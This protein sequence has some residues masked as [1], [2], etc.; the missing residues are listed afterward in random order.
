MIISFGSNAG[1]GISLG[2]LGQN[3]INFYPYEDGIQNY[4]G[5]TDYYDR[6]MGGAGPLKGQPPSSGEDYTRITRYIDLYGNERLVFVMNDTVCV[7]VGNGYKELV[8]LNGDKIDGKYYPSM[9]AHQGKLVILNRG[10]Y[11]YIWDGISAV[12]TIGIHETPGTPDARA[13]IMPWSDTS[14]SLSSSVWTFKNLWWPGVVPDSGPAQNKDFDNVDEIYGIYRV[15]VQFF[16]RYGNKSRLSPASLEVTVDNFDNDSN[17]CFLVMDFVTPQ[18]SDSVYGVMIGRTLSLNPLGGTG[19]ETVF[20]NEATI[21]GTSQ[22]RHTCIMNDTQLAARPVMSNVYPPQTSSFGCSWKGRIFFSGGM[23]KNRTE[24][25]GKTYFGEI[26][27]FYYSKDEV[28]AIVPA[29][30]RLLIVTKSTVE[31]LYETQDGSIA[32]LEID[33]RNGSNHGSTFCDLGNGAVIG[34]FNDGFKI[35]DGQKYT[36][37]KSPYFIEG[38]YWDTKIAQAIFSNGVYYLIARLEYTSTLANN[39]ILMFYPQNMSWWRIDEISYGITDCPDGILITDETIYQAFT[40]DY[41]SES[42][43]E[44]LVVR[45]QDATPFQERNV[46]SMKFLMEPSSNGELRAYIQGKSDSSQSVRGRMMPSKNSS[47][48][49]DFYDVVWNQGGKRYDQNHKWAGHNFVM[50]CTMGHAVTGM[51]HDLYIVVPSGNRVVIKSISLDVAIDSQ[52]TP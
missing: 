48:R 46:V 41:E 23:T 29:G 50:T 25:S 49:G 15:C 31:V 8:T 11:P 5:R 44:M 51:Y 1:L 6:T 17:P 7:K 20:F 21:Y 37:V 35:F 52:D 16:D 33:F 30:D 45:P 24:W 13:T 28:T 27:G 9:F 3:T 18:M 43:I 12:Q 26:E 38:D 19:V 4:P 14:F 40:G 32:V 2:Q 22:S 36:D 47:S 34:L 10:D 39:A 42:S